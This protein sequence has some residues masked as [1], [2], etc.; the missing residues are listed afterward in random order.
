[1]YPIVLVQSR[2]RQAYGAAVSEVLATANKNG[3]HRSRFA[4]GTVF[5]EVSAKAGLWTGLWTV[6][7]GHCQTSYIA[8]T[9]VGRL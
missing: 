9:S 2:D 3:R 4:Y 8:T 1:M 7:I 6:P 5:S